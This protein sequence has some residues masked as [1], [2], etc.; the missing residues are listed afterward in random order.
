M[1]PPNLTK[2]ATGEMKGF[3]EVEKFQSMKKLNIIVSEIKSDNNYYTFH[4][5]L[6]NNSAIPIHTNHVSEP[7]LIISQN[8]TELADEYLKDITTQQ[9]IEN[10]QS[11]SVLVKIAKTK[12]DVSSAVIIY[13]KSKENI[14]GELIAVRPGSFL[15]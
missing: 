15:K 10:A 9:I 13:T 2:M 8:K 1:N 14:R 7:Q 12:I 6:T 5:N 4:F 3:I 11:I